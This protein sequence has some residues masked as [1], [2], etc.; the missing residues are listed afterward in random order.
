M[1]QKQH[2]AV[3]IIAGVSMPMLISYFSNLNEIPLGELINKVIKDGS[4]GIVYVEGAS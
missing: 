3:H 4:R 1:I 2:P